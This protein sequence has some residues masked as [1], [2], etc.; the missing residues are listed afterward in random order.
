VGRQVPTVQLVA[1]PV[2]E[3][4]G[5]GDDDGRTTSLPLRLYKYW[6]CKASTGKC[7]VVGDSTSSPWLKDYFDWAFSIM[8]LRLVSCEKFALRHILN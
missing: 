6:F 8:P 2:M 4:V 7:L 5:G 3:I 1:S